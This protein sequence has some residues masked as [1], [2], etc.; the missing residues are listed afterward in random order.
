MDLKSRFEQ[1]VADS[2]NLTDRPSN[3]TLL[4]L[5]SYYKQA[6]EGDIN[7]DPPSNPFD[8]VSKA[9]FE[10]WAALKGKS[11]DNAMEEYVELI[12]KLKG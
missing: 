4:Q 7:V 1:A 5:Y 10:A 8:F 2:K 6:T 9:K 11:K 12:E 3:D